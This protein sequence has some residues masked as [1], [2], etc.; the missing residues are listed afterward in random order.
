MILYTD[1]KAQIVLY[2]Q[3][4]IILILNKV[5]KDQYERIAGLSNKAHI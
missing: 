3:T 5:I 1:E 4:A 2:A